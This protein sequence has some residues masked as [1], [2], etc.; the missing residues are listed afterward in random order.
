MSDMLGLLLS[1]RQSLNEARQRAWW[2]KQARDDSGRFTE[3][4]QPVAP[5]IPK[6]VA[7][8]KHPRRKKKPG[9]LFPGTTPTPE[10]AQ[11]NIDDLMGGQDHGFGAHPAEDGTTR[12]KH[13]DDP[14]EG[15]PIQGPSIFETVLAMADYVDQISALAARTVGFMGKKLGQA[16]VQLNDVLGN[17]S[18][19]G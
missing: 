19:G 18:M 6:A 11:E 2:A 12:F 7:P 17:W 16:L 5:E 8:E 10:E 9:E 1:T 13:E 14:G 4:P 15:V 3:K